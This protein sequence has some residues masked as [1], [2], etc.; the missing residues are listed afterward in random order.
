MS[1][2]KEKKEPSDKGVFIWGF[3]TA[4]MIIVVVFAVLVF[5]FKIKFNMEEKVH[6]D[7]KNVINE[8]MIDKGFMIKRE[9]GTE[10]LVNNVQMELPSDVDSTEEN[11]NDGTVDDNKET[12]NTS[13]TTENTNKEII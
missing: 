7:N 4:M 10:I 9:D 6:S 2:I 5:G 12:T 3:F 8:S 13:E 1:K 11:T